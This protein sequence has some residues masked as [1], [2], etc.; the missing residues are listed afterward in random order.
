[1]ATY[2]RSIIL[3]NEEKTHMLKH[4]SFPHRIHSILEKQGQ[5]DV[6]FK[7]DAHTH[8]QKNDVIADVLWCSTCRKA[9]VGQAKPALFI[10]TNYQCIDW[11]GLFHFSVIIR[12]R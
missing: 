5:K 10:N 4:V 3:R 2:P 6:F 9:A 11:L 12:E 8:L 7:I 1:M